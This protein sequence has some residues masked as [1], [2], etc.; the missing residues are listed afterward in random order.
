MRL[1]LSN[2]FKPSSNVLTERSKAVFLLWILFVIC[3][4]CL[5][6]ILSVLYS[7]VVKSWVRAD[8]LALLYV[9]FSVCFSHFSIP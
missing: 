6:D 8:L 7:L 3:V 9:M 4:S 2:I 5:S 1:V